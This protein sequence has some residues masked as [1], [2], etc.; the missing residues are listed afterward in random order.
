MNPV[1]AGLPTTIFETMSARARASGAINLGQGFPDS[2]WPQAALDAAARALLEGDNQYPP[3]AGLASLRQAVAAHYATHA[4]QTLDPNTEITIT[5]GATE[6][7]AASLLALLSPGDEVVLFQPLY[8][9]YLPLVRRAGGIPRLVSLR[10]PHWQFTDQ[11]LAA[12]FSPRTRAVLLN[13][14][15]NPSAS[16]FD[17][18]SL[19]QLAAHAERSNAIIIADEVWEHVRFDGR[20]HVSV[21]DVSRLR[22]RAIKI[23]SAGKILALTGWKVGWMVAAPPLTDALRRA[24]QFLTFTTPPNLQ[25][26]VAAGLA[27]PQSWFKAMR[28]GFEAQRD[29]LVHGL[30]AAGYATLPSHAT[31]FVIV[32]LAA[33]GI[34]R[35]DTD[36]AEHLLGHGIA[37]IPVSAFYAEAPVTF[38]LRLCFAKQPGVIDAALE[39]LAVARPALG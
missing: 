15:L 35:P 28:A 22:D 26:G 24:H 33:S 27:L 23:G 2:G 3:M 19:E 29:R 17:R 11:D 13:N 12:A 1:F 20:P 6:A 4:G 14:P 16:T 38:T 18:A 39:R 37:T 5:S 10:P 31:W 30:E 8:D 25:Q 32:D 36:V 7:L 34:H 21:L 9:A